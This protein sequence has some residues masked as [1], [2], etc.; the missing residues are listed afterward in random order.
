LKALRSRSADGNV[1]RVDPL[2]RVH[3]PTQGGPAT[4]VG[5]KAQIIE[6]PFSGQTV[7]VTEIR[8][9]KAKVMLDMFNSMP[10]AVT[11][12]VEQLEAV[13]MTFLKDI[14]SEPHARLPRHRI[15]HWVSHS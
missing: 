9:H 14:G 13:V 3:Q 15:C 11:V 10:V 7:K 1:W 4:Q 6:G 5:G 2:R 12:G 8:N